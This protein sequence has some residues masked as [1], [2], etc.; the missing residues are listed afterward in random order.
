MKENAKRIVIIDD[1][2]DVVHLLHQICAAAG[3]VVESTASAADFHRLLMTRPDFVLLDLLM[4]DIDGVELLRHL[5]EER[6]E[7]AI[8]LISGADSRVL[9]SVARLAATKGLHVQGTLA[10]PFNP[11][12]LLR[13][14][15][16]NPSEHIEYENGVL[17]TVQ[18]GELLSALRENRLIAYFQPQVDLATGKPISCEALVRWQH[19]DQGL[20]FPDRFIPVAEQSGIIGELTENIAAQ[21]FRHCARLSAAGHKIRCAI[22]VSALSLADIRFPDRLITM[23]NSE[24]ISPASVVVEITESRLY[25][26]AAHAMDVLTRLRMKGIELSIDDFGTGY[27]NL[28]QLQ[29]MPFNEL[30]I[31]KG[32]IRNCETDKESESIVRSSIELGQRLAIRT[33]AEGVETRELA[34]RLR[35]WGCNIGQGFFYAKA[36][37][38]THFCSGCA[39][40]D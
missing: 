33:V 31:D 1:E 12:E 28:R 14:L 22:N 4:P 27:S 20:I 8:I 35:E 37:P 32:F 3:Y 5:S 38:P 16:Q 18:P 10:K 6:I 2:P 39:N 19:P 23:L 24:K 29:L 13:L 40:L 9:Q 17:E 26:N 34:E 7:S 15:A 30:K 11:S 21:T 25:D 36:L